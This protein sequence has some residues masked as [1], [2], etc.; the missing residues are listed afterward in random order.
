MYRDEWSRQPERFY[1]DLEAE[2][3]SKIDAAV[4]EICEDPVRAR[5]V[6]PLHGRL[7]G[8]YRRRVG[9]YRLIYRF[10]STTNILYVIVLDDRKEAYRSA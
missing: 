5:N 9:R 1:R 7:R 8:M 2:A 4:R 6:E 10:D 3:K